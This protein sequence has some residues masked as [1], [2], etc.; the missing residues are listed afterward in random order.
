MRPA[1]ALKLAL[2]SVVVLLSGC[3]DGRGHGDTAQRQRLESHCS[4][5]ARKLREVSDGLS[6]SSLQA[7]RT[8]GSAA[9]A[10]GTTACI[11]EG[12]HDPRQSCSP[13]SDYWGCLRVAS[14]RLRLQVALATYRTF[15]TTE[16]QRALARYC[17]GA[18]SELNLVAR[19]VSTS[20]DPQ[21]HAGRL[22]AVDTTACGSDLDED[23]VRDCVDAAD[24]S[25]IALLASEGRADILKFLRSQQFGR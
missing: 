22:W 17:D 16:A 24:A 18:R 8:A 7:R 20:D 1:I 12:L 13:L 23:R 6:A 2:T 19:F 3:S 25:C 4:V 15:T 9:L 11:S 14:E 5:I 21:N 10:I